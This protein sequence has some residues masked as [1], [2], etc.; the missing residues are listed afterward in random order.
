M[1]NSF[2]YGINLGTRGSK[3]LEVRKSVVDENT[4]GWNNGGDSDSKIYG[5]IG[6]MRNSFEYEKDLRTRGPRD[7]KCG[8]RK[9]SRME[10]VNSDSN[11]YGEIASRSLILICIGEGEGAGNILWVEKVHTCRQLGCGSWTP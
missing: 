8:G 11:I 6:W 1:R 7:W 4:A 2:E 3:G 10:G 5:E 9:Y